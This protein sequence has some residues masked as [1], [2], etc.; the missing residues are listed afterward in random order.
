M[1][2]HVTATK[3]PK[4]IR[5]LGKQRKTNKIEHLNFT[6]EQEQQEQEETAI[7]QNN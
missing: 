4:C 7:R 2:N 3:K 5:T 1:N 6:C